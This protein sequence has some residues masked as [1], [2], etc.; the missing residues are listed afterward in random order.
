M[1][2]LRSGFGVIRWTH[3]ELWGLHKKTR[4]VLAKAKFHQEGYDIHRLYLSRKY[5]VPGL[6]GVV[7][8][9]RQDFTKLE[10]YVEGSE[11]PL[12][13]IVKSSEGRQVHGLMS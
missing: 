6:V 10:Q 9:H 2:V 1:P 13:Q 8:N 5:G 7:D 11:D 4:K 12:V 3:M